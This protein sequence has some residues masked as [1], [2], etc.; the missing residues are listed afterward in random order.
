MAIKDTLLSIKSKIVGYVPAILSRYVYLSFSTRLPVYLYP[1][2]QLGHL[3]DT[4]LQPEHVSPISQAR[5]LYHL[6][7][8]FIFQIIPPPLPQNTSVAIPPH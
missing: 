4:M 5:F 3:S 2:P 7:R 6:S 1:L 8:H